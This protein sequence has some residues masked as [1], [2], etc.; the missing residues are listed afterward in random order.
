MGLKDLATILSF[1]ALALAA[2]EVS[3]ADEC[4][5][6]GG[7]GSLQKAMQAAEESKKR[8]CES[9]GKRDQLRS[10]G[11]QCNAQEG[12]RDA[13]EGAKAYADKL[14]E[15]CDAAEKTVR[16]AKEACDENKKAEA[17]AED[18]KKAVAALTDKQKEDPTAVQAA[19]QGPK[20]ALKNQLE[21]ASLAAKN[22]AEKAKLEGKP[23]EA[24][25][26]AQKLDQLAREQAQRRQ[27][28]VDRASKKWGA[29]PTKAC[30]AQAKREWQQKNQEKNQGQKDCR[31]MLTSRDGLEKEREDLDRKAKELAQA[32]Q[33]LD[34]EALAK[35][36]ATEKNMETTGERVADMRSLTDPKDGKP[37]SD[38]T[39]SEIPADADQR[40]KELSRKDAATRQREF[41]STVEPFAR[42]AA[43]KLV[44]SDVTDRQAKVDEA[45]RAITSQWA[46]ETGYCMNSGCRSANNNLGGLGN[47]KGSYA[48]FTDFATRGGNPMTMP[49][50]QGYPGYAGYMTPGPGWSAYNNAAGNFRTGNTDGF[51]RNVSYG[52]YSAAGC[53][54]GCYYR[55]LQG[56]YQ[57]IYGRPP[58]AR[59][60]SSSPIDIAMAGGTGPGLPGTQEIPYSSGASFSPAAARA[61]ATGEAL[62]S[63]GERLPGPAAATTT[64]LASDMKQGRIATNESAQRESASVG[65]LF[66]AEPSSPNGI[67]LEPTLAAEGAREPG[68]APA[69]LA[70]A[71]FADGN[72]PLAARTGGVRYTGEVGEHVAAGILKVASADQNLFQLVHRRYQLT[73]QYRRARANQPN[74]AT[75]EARLGR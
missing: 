75:M 42:A 18:L 72:E 55:A 33:G 40:L 30:D 38:I 36:G 70:A 43:E 51:F 49:A 20:E 10:Q 66:F 64:S 15:V 63:F 6:A 24:K 48:N 53:V 71:E 21:K 73:E 37:A 19:L 11:Q 5:Q 41:A 35:A 32:G 22:A 39:G 9:A 62:A 3:R 74:P 61:L 26:L 65:G 2:P 29:C 4:G 60:G 1:G 23:E 44:P 14:K 46:Y 34:K 69:S 12:P 7:Q 68:R 57:N 13:E 67:E 16:A 58:P 27:Q 45:T 31:S 47:T 56:T 54:Q 59:T 52:G 17:R 25:A 8:H 28:A 50:R